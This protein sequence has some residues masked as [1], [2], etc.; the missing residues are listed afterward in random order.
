[1]NWEILK[2]DENFHIY[3]E[4]AVTILLVI[5]F[6]IVKK[7]LSRFIIKHSIHENEINTRTAYIIKL[8][9]F[10]LTLVFLTLLA[11]V[12]EVSFK[13]L[14]IYFASL[15]TIVGVAFFASWSILSNI[16]AYAII[17]F[18][19]PF[20]IG[21]AISIIDGDNTVEGLVDD[22]TF[23]FIKIKLPSGELV[24]YPNNLAIQKP[25]KHLAKH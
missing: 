14:S 24:T 8:T 22:I 20:K 25:I 7:V 9:N 11:I 17:F 13:G 6:F 3:A 16:T 12:W 21:S 1:M 23:F 4:I 19:F 5:A 2:G 18:N 15:F 10:A